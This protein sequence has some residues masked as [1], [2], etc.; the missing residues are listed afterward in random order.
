M[1]SFAIFRV[2]PK[3]TLADV[4]AATLHGRREDGGT[5]FDPDRTLLNRHWYAG[6]WVKEPVDWSAAIRRAIADQELHV[7]GNGAIAAELFLGASA[8]FFYREDGSIDD[9]VLDEWIAAN[10]AWLLVTFPRMVLALRVDL[11]ESTPHMCVLLLPIYEKTTRH[12]TKRA[13]SHRQVFG[14]DNKAKTSERMIALRDSYAAALAPLGLSRGISKTITHREHLS[15]PEYAARKAREDAERK[16]AVAVA[17]EAEHR[18]T[19]KVKQAAMDR[20]RAADLLSAVEA[21]LTDVESEVE[22][23]RIRLDW[24]RK[25]VRRMSALLPDDYLPDGIDADLASLDQQDEQTKRLA[26][27]I[28]VLRDRAEEIRSHDTNALIGPVA[29][30]NGR[31]RRGVEN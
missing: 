9:E 21:L 24:S 13:V 1:I 10:I 19:G 20:M 14:G 17:R 29:T 2:E 12:M 3:R 18:A 26:D 31:Q 7:R 4:H 11:D 6:E 15:H 8:A 28:A 27:R 22:E 23:A 16:R 5:H 25:A 30:P